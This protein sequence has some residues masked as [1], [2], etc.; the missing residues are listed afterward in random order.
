M[1]FSMNVEVTA[2]DVADALEE[3]PDLCADALASIIGLWGA[4][5]NMRK[6]FLS[7]FS[8]GLAQYDPATQAAV[9]V[10]LGQM[11]AVSEIGAVGGEVPL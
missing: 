8:R 5:Q 3:N 4:D 10:L 6:V 2:D 9:S 7:G 11:C 1:A